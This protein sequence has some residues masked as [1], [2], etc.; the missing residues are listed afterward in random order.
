M[1]MADFKAVALAGLCMSLPIKAW[2]FRGVFDAFRA[3]F[4]CCERRDGSEK[5]PTLTK[6]AWGTRQ[7]GTLGITPPSSPRTKVRGKAASSRRAP[8]EKG[9][10][11]TKRAW[12]TRKGLERGLR[13]KVS[14][15]F[16]NA[17][18]WRLEMGSAVCF[19]QVKSMSN[20][21][22]WIRNEGRSGAI[23]CGRRVPGWG[24]LLYS[25][26]RIE[27]SLERR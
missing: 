16:K 6:R 24:G 18:N 23:C 14:G 15:N 19:V 11:L 7:L 13:G 8:K 20:S 21:G 5:S 10:T 2:R 12:G 3:S 27:F 22:H 9:P 25:A 17:K 1:E 4:A 26:A